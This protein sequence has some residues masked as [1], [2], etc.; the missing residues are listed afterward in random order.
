[1]S[2]LKFGIN[3]GVRILLSIHGGPDLDI[4]HLRA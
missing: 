2:L 4:P 3:D 1:M